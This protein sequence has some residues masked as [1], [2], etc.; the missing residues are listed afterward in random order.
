MSTLFCVPLCAIA[1]FETHFDRSRSNDYRALM[2]EPDDFGEQE[3]DP[4]PCYKSDD[5]RPGDDEEMKIATTSFEELKGMLPD[6]TRS[7][8]SDI[9]SEVSSCAARGPCWVS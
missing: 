7:I 1:L 6:L 8:Q 2:E 5:M 3:E 4:E 9:L